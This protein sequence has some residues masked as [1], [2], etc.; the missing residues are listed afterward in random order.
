MKTKSILIALLVLM[1]T[2]VQAQI[3]HFSL[4]SEDG[5]VVW[6]IFP[7]AETPMSGEKLS[8]GNTVKNAVT[9][10]VP[11]TVFA[12]Y[13]RA[14]KEPCPEYGDNIYKVDEALYN[15]RSGTLRLSG[16]PKSLRQ[17]SMCGS[18]L[19]TPTSLLISG[20]T[21]ISCRARSRQ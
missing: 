8:S 21:V 17:V 14:G 6:K 5:N 7:Q 20:L 1:F 3:N 4:N 12:S 16:F 11:G 13:V 9:G 15:V 18:A 2:P 10:I 19:R